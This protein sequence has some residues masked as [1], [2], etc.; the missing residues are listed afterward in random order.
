MSVIQSIR[1]KGTWVIFGIIALALIAFILQDGVG[2]GRSANTNTNIGIV[3]GIKIDRLAFEEKLTMQ[4]RMYGAQGAQREQLIGSV[5]N[6]EVERIVLQQEYEKLG[7]QVTSKELTDILFGDNSPLKNEFTDPKTGQFKI[8]EAKQAFAQIKKSKNVEQVNMINSAYIE[9]TIEQALR[10]KYQALLQQ[11]AYVPKWMVEKQIADN[12]AL[13]SISYAYAPYNSIADSTVKVSDDEIVSYVINHSAEFKK[14]EESRG[15]SYVS[16]NAAAS[17]V[18]S[19]AVL[20]QLL[21]YRTEFATNSDTKGFLNKVGSDLPFYDSYFGKNKLQMTMKDSLTSLSVGSIYGPYL[22]GGSYVMAKMVGVKNWPDS[23]T[24]RHILIGTANPQT[25]QQIKPDSVGKKVA[26]SIAMAIKGGADFN[27]LCIKYSDDAGSKDKGGVYPYFEQG[28]MVMAFNDY[29]FNNPVGSKSVV[30]TDFGYH[31]IEIIG[32]KNF[33]PAYKIGYLA[34]PIVASNETVSAANTVAAQFASTS[35]NKK[36]FNENALKS[37][38]QLMTAAEIKANDNQITGIGASRTLIR[39]VYD[40]SI[41]AVSEPTEIGDKYVVAILT[42]INKVGTMSA[43]EARPMVESIVRSNKKAKILID[44]KFKGTTLE[45]LAGS[46]GTLVQ[47]ADSVSFSTPF[48]P[49]VGSEPK[50]IGAAFNKSLQGKVS[51][52]IAGTS[53]VFAIRV[54]NNSAKPS[55]TDVM[56]MKQNLIQ[57]ARMAAYR[58]AEALRKSAKIEDNRSLFY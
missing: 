12:N 29:V 38:F 39:W 22:D 24:V 43:S 25:G 48:I 57:A 18:D 3:N 49:N 34:K 44:S 55:T 19:S 58:G 23:V 50:V 47:R 4:E 15:I 1:D 53:G 27:A 8:A 28:K 35:K 21:S 7:L 10:T 41:G 26:D 11:S 17:S 46:V 54:E 52:P 30:K 40:N 51:E 14:E 45:A 2:R 9:P 32:Q 16:F 36:S 37:S 42:S 5:W 20:N 56:A 6:Q 13:S 31:Y 33:G